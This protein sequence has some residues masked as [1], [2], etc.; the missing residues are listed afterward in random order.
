MTPIQASLKKSEGLVYNNLLDQRKKMKPKYQVNAL[1]RTADLKKT[2][3][4]S[5]MTNS[6][7]LYKTSEI[8]NDKI[9]SY[10][11]DSFPERYNEALLIKT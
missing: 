6:Y 9:P 4:K 10:H 1:V 3:S 8:I 2:F 11:I 5:D 7:N